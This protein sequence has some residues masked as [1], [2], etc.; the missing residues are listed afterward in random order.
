[1]LAGRRPL[2][3]RDVGLADALG[4]VTAADVTTPEPIPPFTSSAMDGY[5]VRSADTALAPVD[6]RVIGT[7]MAGSSADPV[8]DAGQA[9]RIMTGARFPAGADA[10][11][12]VE[13]TQTSDDGTIV[14][15][16]TQVAPGENVR[17]AGGDVA[18]GDLVLGTGTVLSPAGIGVLASVGMLHVAVH[19]RPRV[20][21]M[22]TGDELSEGPAALGAAKIRDSNRWSLL[23]LVAQSGFTGVDLGIV[24]DDED[25]VAQALT[26]GARTCDAL[27]TSGGVS[28][29]DRDVVKAV[30]DALAPDGGRWMQIAVRPGKPFAFGEIGPDATPVFGLPG[31]PVSAMVSFELFARPALR[32]MAG[33]S[34]LDRPHLNAVADAPMRRSKDGKLHLVRVVA[35]LGADGLVHVTSAGPQGSHQMSAMARANALALLPDGDGVEAGGRVTTMLLDAGELTAAR[36]AQDELA[37]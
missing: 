30:I 37:R 3:P 29:G 8:V 25:A 22:S 10:V 31:N 23:A 12:M 16:G 33:H 28:V 2:A 32:R 21:V 20:G 11:C 15:I 9:V 36:S 35:T 26:G 4:C 7:V 34:V 27:L 14:S 5:A 19:P 1:M 6:L 24:G 13:R 18:A 17:L